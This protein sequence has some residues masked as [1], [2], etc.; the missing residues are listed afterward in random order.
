MSD[1]SITRYSLLDDVLVELS[2]AGVK[3]P[4]ELVVRARR[5]LEDPRYT[6]RGA[7]RVKTAAIVA[8][9]LNEAG[10][11]VPLWLVMAV[12]GMDG[13]VYRAV[14]GEALRLCGLRE[15]PEHARVLALY[16]ARRLGLG[17]EEAEEIAEAAARL[18]E[19]LGNSRLA[20]AAALRQ[21][22]RSYIEIQR[23]LGVAH[24]TLKEAMSRIGG[25]AVTGHGDA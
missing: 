18:V 25:Q 8:C 13:R 16:A 7:T 6:A 23:V 17:P 12:A 14:F 15:G 24:K 21:A 4:M 5:L 11:P 3:V 22:G 1:A 20:A 2:R 19:K 10:I 9:V